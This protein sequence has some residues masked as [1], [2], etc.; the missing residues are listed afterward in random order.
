MEE[1]V[2]EVEDCWSMGRMVERAEEP[3][4]PVAPVRIMC[5][6]GREGRWGN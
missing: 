3:T 4:T 1:G 5:A 2:E 6:I